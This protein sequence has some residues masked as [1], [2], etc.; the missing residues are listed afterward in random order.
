MSDPLFSAS[1]Y[2]VKDLAPRLRPHARVV[3][4]RYRGET[5]YV[6]HDVASDRFLRFTPAA[7]QLL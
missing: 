5:W 2:R 6:L 3:R 7:N 4:H 1:W